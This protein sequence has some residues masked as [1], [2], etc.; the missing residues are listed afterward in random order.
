MAEGRRRGGI[1]GLLDLIDAHRGAFEYDWRTRFHLSLEV[2]PESMGWDE[3]LR[4]TQQLTLDPSSHVAAAVAGWAHPVSREWAVTAD[5]FDLQHLVAAGK[6]KPKPYP[7]PWG[8]AGRKKLTMASP[9]RW[10]QIRAE[11]AEQETG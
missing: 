9:E 4:L 8:K 2:V 10:A 11:L 1:L 5:L 3:A 7:R 6:S